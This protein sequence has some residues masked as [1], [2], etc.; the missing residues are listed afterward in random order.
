MRL[1]S[2]VSTDYSTSHVLGFGATRLSLREVGASGFALA[3]ESRATITRHDSTSIPVLYSAD[4]RL[5]FERGR[6]IV[7]L[8]IHLESTSDASRMPMQPGYRA[9]GWLIAPAAIR[10]GKGQNRAIKARARELVDL[11]HDSLHLV[12]KDT[13]PSRRS[14]QDEKVVSVAYSARAR[15]GEMVARVGYRLFSLDEA[16]RFAP[17]PIE[18]LMS[19]EEPSA[20]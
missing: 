16:T 17:L 9:R 10:A 15:F 19:F 1:G 20:L 5:V 13:A 3:P 6:L 7:Q 12:R 11:A 18:E 2:S 14:D 4:I 8:P